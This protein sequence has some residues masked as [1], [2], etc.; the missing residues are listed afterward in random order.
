MKDMLMK[1]EEKNLLSAWGTLPRL[2]HEVHWWY[3][4]VYQ[5]NNEEEDDITWI[6]IELKR[7]DEQNGI[8]GDAGAEE[9]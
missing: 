9:H 5:Q 6:W 8:A 7:G 2:W 4:Y 1:V 3:I